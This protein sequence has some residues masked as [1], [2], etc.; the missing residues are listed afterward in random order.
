MESTQ[1]TRHS[2][3]TGFAFR[4]HY[5]T[6]VLAF[7]EVSVHH[8]H[9]WQVRLL[10]GVLQHPHFALVAAFHVAVIEGDIGI[11]WISSPNRPVITK[12]I[13]ILPCRKK[14]NLS[15]SLSEKDRNIFNSP[16]NRRPRL[17]N[18]YYVLH[19]TLVCETTGLLVLRY[20]ATSAT[21]MNGNLQWGTFLGLRKA[22]HDV[23]LF[24]DSRSFILLAK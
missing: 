21:P 9:A 7:P 15:A 4:P 3:G 6:V 16:G 23:V 19:I 18:T 17:T 22:N 10:L 14:D 2:P 13:G 12:P 11:S 8:P 5:S 20:L 1:V 24:Q